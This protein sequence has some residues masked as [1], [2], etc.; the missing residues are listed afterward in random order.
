VIVLQLLFPI[1]L[2]FGDVD[3]EEREKPECQRKTSWSKG[4]NQQQNSIHKLRRRQDLN[5]GHVGGSRVLSLLYHP[6]P[7]PQID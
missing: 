6:L 1:E 2:E 3:F 5:R 7:A 4:E